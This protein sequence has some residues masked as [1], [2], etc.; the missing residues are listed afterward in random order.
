MSENKNE[1]RE[2][3]KNE[4][5][6]EFKKEIEGELKSL[7]DNL[8][9]IKKEN[10]VLKNEIK[11]KV[12][13]GNVVIQNQIENI[14]FISKE[15]KEFA[16]ES[17]KKGLN[18]VSSTKSTRPIA[19][20]AGIAEDI[21]SNMLKRWE[22][23]SQLLE[24]KTQSAYTSD[25]NPYGGYMVR[26]QYSPSVLD[27]TNFTNEEILLSYFGIENVNS[28]TYIVDRMEYN[29]NTETD[30]VE[31]YMEG[32]AFTYTDVTPLYKPLT[33]ELKKFMKGFK[34]SE[35]QFLEN[36][37]LQNYR[38]ATLEKDIQRAII[39]SIVAKLSN[40]K[41]VKSIPT[42]MVSILSGNVVETA[43]TN[44]VAMNDILSRL[45]DAT[46]LLVERLE[47]PIILLNASL[48]NK[49]FQEEDFGQ[50]HNGQRI[51][52]EMKKI[53][54]A[55]GDI[56]FV[57]INNNTLFTNKIANAT[58]GDTV[59]I[60]IDKSAYKLLG[61]SKGATLTMNYPHDQNEK[62]MIENLQSMYFG[63]NVVDP[64]KIAILKV[65]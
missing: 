50:Y 52:S 59:A 37:Q 49:F 34:I 17:F 16:F 42:E 45:F 51:N 3:F 57:G 19:I 18:E 39:R 33:I 28:F 22:N 55:W 21:A 53:K 2:T 11:S 9:E 27:I 32:Q 60:L 43:T 8:I 30:N 5:K 56:D 12:Q 40:F 1:I 38:L 23:K 10:E 62:G 31:D 24:T 29:F 25:S 61:T 26:P 64:Y 41:C 35:K 15:K 44:T 4:I 54:T 58:T 20:D 47:K 7:Q 46:N 13:I 48:L 6:S 65:R 14:D 36:P 63:G